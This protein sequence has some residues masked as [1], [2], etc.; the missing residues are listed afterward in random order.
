MKIDQENFALLVN[1]A[2]QVGNVSHMRS[3][4]E[5]TLT[6]RYFICARKRWTSKQTDFSRWHFITSLL[7]W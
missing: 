1:K 3:V 4:I 5:R 2:M 6:L 7:W